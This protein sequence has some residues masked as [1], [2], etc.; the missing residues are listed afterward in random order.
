MASNTVIEKRMSEV[1]NIAARLGVDRYIGTDRMTTVEAIVAEWAIQSEGADLMGQESLWLDAKLEI[2]TILSNMSLTHNSQH[3]LYLLGATQSGAMPLNEVNESLIDGWNKLLKIHATAIKGMS[4]HDLRTIDRARDSALSKIPVFGTVEE[5]QIAISSARGALM[6]L[7]QTLVAS[8]KK[9]E[10]TQ[11]K[12]E[13]A[14]RMT[15]KGMIL[16]EAKSAK[17]Q[18]LIPYG[19]YQEIESLLG[20]NGVFSEQ[21]NSIGTFAHD[22]NVILEQMD[23]VLDRALSILNREA[24]ATSLAGGMF[25]ESERQQRISLLGSTT[26][27]GDGFRVSGNENAIY[28]GPSPYGAVSNSFKLSTPFDTRNNP[29][30]HKVNA[31]THGAIKHKAAGKLAAMHAKKNEALYSTPMGGWTDKNPNQT[32]L[33]ATATVVAGFYFLGKVFSGRKKVMRPSTYDKGFSNW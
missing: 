16:A 9:T 6:E 28:R 23:R 13:I 11:M 26:N 12:G 1:S 32:A 18:S 14:N 27:N 24:G 33:V 2:E 30:E 31:E 3:D 25:V 10:Q 21:V 5:K 29:N 19:D 20:N 22:P 8:S 15:T 4:E 7:E 17:K